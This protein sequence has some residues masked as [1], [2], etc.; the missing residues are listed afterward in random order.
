MEVTYLGHACYLIKI[1]ELNILVDPIL[2]NSF[3]GEPQ[4]L[5]R[6]VQ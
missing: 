6:L 4:R 3:Q 5:V 2:T 1:N